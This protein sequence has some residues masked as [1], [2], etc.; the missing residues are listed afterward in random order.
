VTANERRQALRRAPLLL[1]HVLCRGRYDFVYDQMP[2]GMRGMSARKRLNLAMA[3]LN[4][5]FRRLRPWSMPLHLQLE[6]TNYCNLHCA[7]CPTGSGELTRRPQ[8]MSPALAAR[9]LEEVGPYLLTLTLWGWGESLLHPDLETILQS[10]AKQPAATLLSTNGGHLGKDRV[11]EALSRFPPTFLIV[12]IDGLTDATNA[13][14]RV[15][16]KLAP[17]LDAVRTLADQKARARQHLPILQMRFIVMK[18]NLHEVPRLEEFAAAHGFDQVAL[19][20]LSI[21]TTPAGRAAHQN[22]SLDAEG[23]DSPAVAGEGV[24]AAFICQQP[25]WF[26]SVYADGTVV[27]CEQDCN[28]EAP[29][30][31]MADGASFSEVWRGRQAEKVRRQVRDAP[32]TLTCCQN[33]PACRRP[34][35]DTSSRM[36]T[37]NPDVGETTTIGGCR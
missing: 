20:R 19:R 18:H 35:T 1:W 23:T 8:A 32:E 12:A 15:G 21:V 34:I 22:L 6:L 9:V 37:I 29:L 33:C 5:G 27:A 17:V 10:V 28:A 14:L 24:G 7:V 4:L 16:A 11:I 13:R 3:G 26:P 25:F 30:G 36:I 31:T 2:I